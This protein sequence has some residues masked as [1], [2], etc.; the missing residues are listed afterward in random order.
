MKF[1]VILL[2]IVIPIMNLAAQESITASGGNATGN[3]GSVSY[4]LGQVVFSFKTGIDGWVIEGVQQPYEISSISGVKE[5]FNIN[6]ICTVYPNPAT[7]LLILKV[8][9][10]IWKNLSYKLIDI[11][12]KVLQNKKINSYESS[13]SLIQITAGIYFLKVYDNRRNIKTFKIIKN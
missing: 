10:L 9:T 1:S 8:E 13:I 4:S 7:D 6:L 2:L 3:I 5:A 11:N 12:G